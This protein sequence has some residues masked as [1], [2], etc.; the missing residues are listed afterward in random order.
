MNFILNIIWILFGGLAMAF[1]WLI[2]A[3]IMFVSIVGIP[4]G[5]AALNI[6]LFHLVPF[7][8]TA[9]DREELTGRE[10]IG[11]GPLGFIGNVLWFLVAGIWLAIGHFLLGLGFMV[12]IIGIPFGWQHWK[13][14]R[15]A[16]A[17]IGKA[18]IDREVAEAARRWR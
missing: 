14:A 1:G 13:L 6:A 16:L 11:T 15:M 2:A 12:T 10:D 9:I 5:R 17:P 4:W 8:R 3:L 18:V 7:G